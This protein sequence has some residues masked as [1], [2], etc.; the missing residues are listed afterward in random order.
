MHQIKNTKLYSHYISILKNAYKL[1]F[2]QIKEDPIE[3]CQET[4]ISLKTCE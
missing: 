2:F 3:K 1:I 4:N